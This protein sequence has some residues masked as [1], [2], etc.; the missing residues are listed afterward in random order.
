MTDSKH[1]IYYQSGEPVKVLEN[2]NRPG[3][4]LRQATSVVFVDY[5]I[6]DA[7][8]DALCSIVDGI[9]ADR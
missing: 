6:A 8:I 7:L 5:E 3:I 4:I 2:K 1:R 9:E